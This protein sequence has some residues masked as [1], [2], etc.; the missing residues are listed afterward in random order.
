MKEPDVIAQTVFA[1]PAIAREPRILDRFTRDLELAG[2]VGE[3]KLGCL[4]YLAVT[5]RLDRPVSIGV[6]GPSAGGKSFTIDE[7]LSFFPTTAFYVLSSMSER[8]LAYSEEPLAHRMLVIYEAAGLNSDLASYLVR[9][10]LSEGC[11]RYETVEKTKE[12]L[13][14]RLI[15]R[16][17]PTGLI[18]TTTAI[19]LHPEN[20]TRL[21]SVTVNDT[22]AQ[23]ARILADLASERE[24]TVDRV[25][26]HELQTWLERG[27]SRVRLPFARVLAE[28]VPPAA[29]RLRRD[30]G[31]FL[32][33]IRAHAILHSFNRQRDQDGRI[34]AT[35]E[36]YD[37]V[38]EIVADLIAEGVE[39]TVSPTVRETVAAVGALVVQHP[40]GIG[41]TEIGRLLKL[42]KSAIS[43]RARTAS[44]LG[45]LLNRE[46][47]R[48][49]PARYVLG[50]PL[51]DELELLPSVGTL[52]DRCTVAGVSEGDKSVDGSGQLSPPDTPATL[53]HPREPGWIALQREAGEEPEQDE[54]AA[55]A[56]LKTELGATERLA[57]DAVVVDPDEQELRA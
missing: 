10:L 25:P 55:L 50:E 52:R 6:K 4:V 19:S 39:A 9:S 14:A 44:R 38:R 27:E 41:L 16:P 8:A 17:G 43:R 21:L 45:Y 53:Q 13:K 54:D 57:R 49:K 1:E 31:A 28:L 11:V 47:R 15:Y 51:P 30:F 7:V 22:A 20:E 18:V 5:S 23:T 46:D 3:R 26:W 40:D 42:D 24:D 32:S 48:G 2:V 35:F 56:R 29:V 12:G 34:V 36:D 33:L 37:V